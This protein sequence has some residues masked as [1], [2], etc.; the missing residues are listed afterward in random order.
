MGEGHVIG[1]NGESAP[2]GRGERSFEVWEECVLEG[3]C[4]EP[5]SPTW[6]CLYQQQPECQQT[7]H[8]GCV[9]LVKVARHLEVL[10]A[11]S[12]S[13]QAVLYTHAGTLSYLDPPHSHPTDGEDGER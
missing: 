1:V 11:P 13:P 9:L 3:L 5:T 4:Q 12:S 6:R 2:V 7:T 8:A 10:N